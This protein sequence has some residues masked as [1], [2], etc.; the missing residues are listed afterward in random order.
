MLRTTN[1]RLTTIF[2]QYRSIKVQRW[3]STE[4]KNVA[5]EEAL[6][7]IQAD[8]AERLEMLSRVEKELARVKD[9]SSPTQSAQ[10]A[11]LNTLKYDLQV[12]AE[13]NDPEVRANFENNQNIDMSRPVYRYLT[14][15]QFEKQPR[16]KLLERI[17]QMN[18]APDVVD[19]DVNPTVEIKL[20]LDDS[21][22]IEPG[23]FTT[24]EQ[25]ISR[26]HIQVTNFH[27]ERRLYTMMLVDPDSPDV[28][29]KTYQQHCHWLI[30]NVPLSATQP[31]V[32]D[33][34]TILDYIPP[35][36]QK[37]T[38]AHRY[39]LIAYEQGNQ[40]QDT[41]DS[42]TVNQR[43]GFDAKTFAK[44]HG[45]TVRGV[46][47]FRQK[48]NESVSKIYSDILGIKEPIYGKPPKPERIIQRTMYI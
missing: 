41:L 30:T 15:R 40:G 21:S 14:Q 29:N 16:A 24:P 8:K 34:N 22:I 39:T 4:T 1:K 36:P 46:T 18:V 7:L 17:T 13:L 45:L 37:G 23:V 32:Q 20:Q 43:D 25:S 27:T 35:H 19:I 38:K 26:P 9:T 42:V 11:A 3:A 48:W 44:E 6:K 33:G 47:F 31:T 2:N 10:L 28:A 12:K 5:Y